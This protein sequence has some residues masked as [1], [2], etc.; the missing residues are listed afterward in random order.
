MVIR[1]ATIYPLRIFFGK[2]KHNSEEESSPYED[3]SKGK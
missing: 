1:D 2:R 3:R